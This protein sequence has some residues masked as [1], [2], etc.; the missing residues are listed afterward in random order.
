MRFSRRRFITDTCADPSIA[1][2]EMIRTKNIFFMTGRISCWQN[3]PY[4]RYPAIIFT[5]NLHSVHLVIITT[6]YICTPYLSFKTFH[7][8][9]FITS[10]RLQ[11]ANDKDYAVLSR[12]MKKNSFNP[13]PE[14][15]KN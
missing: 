7:M 10:I 12:E 5:K 3:N 15:K 11:G 1:R 8:P 4:S 9:K 13:V 6:R 14:S 2:N